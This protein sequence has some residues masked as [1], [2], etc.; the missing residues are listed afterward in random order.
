MSAISN[1][2]YYCPRCDRA[3][4][5]ER[6]ESADRELKDR[7]GVDRLSSLRCPVCDCEYI[8]LDKVVKGGEMFASKKRKEA[9]PA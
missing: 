4:P 7:F 9:G 8:D 3:I 6:V 2:V 5:K 1:D